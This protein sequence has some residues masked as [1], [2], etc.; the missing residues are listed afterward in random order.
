M[1]HGCLERLWQLACHYQ[2]SHP[3]QSRYFCQTILR[4]CREGEGSLSSSSSSSFRP[5]NAFYQAACG[6][7]GNIY[8]FGKT[9]RA[10]IERLSCLRRRRR[11]EKLIFASS[12]DD[13]QTPKIG[14]AIHVMV[15]E[16]LVCHSKIVFDTH[17]VMMKQEKKSICTEEE[18]KLT[19][20]EEEKKF[21]EKKAF[22]TD[23]QPE[24]AGKPRT[25]NKP[26]LSKTEQLR[27]LLAKKKNTNVS[28]DTAPSLHSFLKSLKKT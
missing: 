19:C 23:E 9:C 27:K 21:E 25:L 2:Y 26:T 14:G 24:P 3:K 22:F 8:T 12:L 10:R 7:C 17:P 1:D 11:N 18:K 4:K 5:S 13:Q 28:D 15:Y 6:R 16:C 20:T